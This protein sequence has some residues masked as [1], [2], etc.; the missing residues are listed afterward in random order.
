MPA[1]APA[2][3]QDPDAAYPEVASLRTA[4]RGHDW[5]VLCDLF[6]DVDAATRTHLVNVVAGWGGA[7]NLLRPRLSRNPD[8]P[9]ASTLFG[10]ALVQSGWR[11]RTTARAALVSAD[12]FDRFH[13]HLR[14]AEQ[15]LIDVTARHPDDAAAWTQRITLAR[16]LELGQ[17]EARRRYDR[18]ARHH[19]HHLAAQSSLLQQFCPKWSGSW[20]RAHGF[21]RE[22]VEAAPP[23]AH[24][25]A[26]V[27]E[28][29]LEE[30]AEVVQSLPPKE[31][32][33][34]GP[35]NHLRGVADEIHA[36]AERSVRHPDF[37]HTIGWV[38]VRSTF[39]AAFD[40][41]GDQDAAREQFDAL[42]P[43][44]D[45]RAFRYLGDG[46]AQQSRARA[47]AYARSSAR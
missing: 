40:V 20:E 22:C 24:Q 4:L 32:A 25:A 47:Q 44:G 2:Q 42:G 23:G 7:E 12:R 45:P 30:M 17:A 46:R 8:D 13:E 18:L 35:R 16:G 31:Q 3:H 33:R 26:L 39:A 15:V 6:A 14:R 27:V 41:L 10:A 1:P 19:P 36:A 43:Y 38:T 34:G 28:A 5:P 9:L 11:I 37:R 29:H 21:A